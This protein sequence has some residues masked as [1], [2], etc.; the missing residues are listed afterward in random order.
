VQ[1]TYRKA[2]TGITLGIALVVCPRAFASGSPLD[3]SQYAHMSWRVRDGFVTGIISSI[4]QTPDG[5]LWLGTEFGLVRFDGVQPK[6]WPLPAGQRLPANR[7][8]SLLAA[9]DGTLWI[10]TS[11]GLA[12][13]KDGKLT[14]YPQ[15]AGQPIRAA[16]VEDHDGTIWAGGLGSAPQGT[17]CAIQK[18][19][20]QCYGEDGR[21]ENG[22]SGLY[23]DR[24][25]NLWVGVRN[26]VWRWKPGPP[27]FYDAPGPAANG[28]G[29][30]GFAESADGALL[31][32][33]RSGIARIAGDAIEP[34]SLPGAA[35][36]FTAVRLLSDRGGNL[37]VGTAEAGLVHVHDGRTDVFAQGDGLSGDFIS[38][39]FTDR[40]GT[41]WVATIGGLD[42]FREFA[43]PTLTLNQGLLNTSILSVLADRD[44]SVWLSTR[45]GLNRWNNGQI[46]IF[47]SSHAARGAKPDGMLNGNYAGSMFQDRR[48]RIWAS[49]LREFGYLENDRF[50]PLK[51]VP[52]GAV[53]SMAEDAAGNLW[54]ANKDRGLIRLLA[55]GD[56]E[57]TPWTSL[58]HKDPAM[59]L[60]FDPAGRGLWIGFNQGGVA[61]VSG[62][63]VRAS[64]IAANGLGEGRVNGLWFDAGGTLWAATE[65]G[66]SRLKNGS[67]ATLSSKNGLPCDGVHW[68]LE[69]NDRSVWLYTTCGL[70]RIAR[71]ELDTWAVAHAK[72]FDSSDGVRSIEDHGGYTPHA[73]KSSDGRIWFLP[74]DGASVIVPRDIPVNRLPPP[75]YIESVKI[76]GKE[77]APAQGLALSHKSNDIEIDY[78]ALSMAIPERVR[79]R[80]LLEGKDTEWQDVGTRRQAYYDNLPPRDYRFRVMASNNDGVWNE[81]G[82]SWSFRIVPTFYQTVWFQTLCVLAAAGLIWLVYRFRLRQMSARINLLY[83]ERLAERT[84]IA[85]DLHDTLLQSLAGVSLQLH[86]I[87]KQAVTAPEKTPGMIDRIRQQVD[88]AFR[89]ARM[90]VYNLRSPAIEGQS[91]AE[92]L[93]DFT[94][95]LG[96]MATAKCGLTVVGEPRAC[97]PEIEE[98]L[99][100]IAQEAA[101]NANRHAQ[102]SEIRIALDYGASSLK[103]AISDDGRG[104]D[105]DE[106]LG[107]SG[108]WGLKNMQE[109]AGHI[110]GKCTITSAPGRGTQVEVHV[111]LRVWSLRNNLVKR[112]D[113]NCGS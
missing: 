35:P 82:A 21:F 102:A 76:N 98:E 77:A 67:A 18:S 32:G 71:S 47:G 69:D 2:L 42:R 34:Y 106:G 83:N 109:R 112:A 55:D 88:A 64:Y 96:P 10:G 56:F 48:G 37:W 107:K 27:K 13:L 49:T 20:V 99:L 16:I 72:V 23:E 26:G 84:R 103:L 86:G 62:G 74:Q 104:F 60:A 59:A 30:Q 81:A 52:G 65:G 101:N 51:N 3:V 33:P 57:L 93:S 14:Q 39:L 100:R 73:A 54:I 29:V 50:V 68:M 19:G 111:P 80:Y 4:A 105:L 89:E 90:K 66:L 28:S 61:L 95:R 94:E 110:R 70:V 53:Y 75:V 15:L 11:R 25:R 87:S 43:A 92:A 63:Q 9:R 38:A 45:R 91:L 85:R 8:Y 46:S 24:N 7:I 5:Y 12:S 79:F 22:V 97:T 58:G 41:I 6:P 31:F 78:T 108:H 44:G 40:E 17:L 113:T 36:Q 1:Q